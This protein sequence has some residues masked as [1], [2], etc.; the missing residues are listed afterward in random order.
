MGGNARILSNAPISQWP[1]DAIFARFEV[2]TAVKIQVDV[3]WV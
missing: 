2:L 3:L 1:N